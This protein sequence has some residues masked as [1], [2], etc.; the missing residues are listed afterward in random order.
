M[1][2]IRRNKYRNTPTEVDGHRFASKLEAKRYGEL[3][4]LQK[5]GQISNLELQPRH[6]LSVNDCLICTFVADFEYLEHGK[7]VAEDAK[8]VRTDVFR[9]KAN[10]FRALYPKIELREI[11]K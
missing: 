8:G 4:L 1:I 2:S 7:R 10:L 5:A 6:P 11:H 9:I 3:K